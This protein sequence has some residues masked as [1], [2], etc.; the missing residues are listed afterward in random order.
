MRQRPA[1]AGHGLR[2]GDQ[3]G[4]QT[5][6][7]GF[8]SSAARQPVCGALLVLN[9]TLPEGVAIGTTQHAG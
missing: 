5:R 9:R 2:S 1:Q 7:A 6:P 4:L 8:N 3:A